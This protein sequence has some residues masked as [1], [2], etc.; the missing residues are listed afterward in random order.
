MKKSNII[1]VKRT[2]KRQ[3]EIKKIR[4]I[5]VASKTYQ[6]VTILEIFFSEKP[7]MLFGLQTT[8]LKGLMG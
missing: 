4:K 6:S 8:T 7:C 2:G 1:I 3:A 5:E